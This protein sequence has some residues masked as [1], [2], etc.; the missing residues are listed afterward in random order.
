[1][2]SDKWSGLIR[3]LAIEFGGEVPA[4]LLMDFLVGRR[5][6]RRHIQPQPTQEQATTADT[7][8]PPSRAVPKALL[9]LKLTS[10]EDEMHEVIQW[11][12]ELSKRSKSELAKWD[13][14]DLEQLFKLPATD[15]T[16]LMEGILGPAPATP[17]SEV[18]KAK[19]WVT[20]QLPHL[21][22]ESWAII[23]EWEDWADNILTPPSHP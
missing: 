15:R 21:D 5:R 8:A 3:E 17:I 2:R 6:G 7:I 16:L 1:M 23:K 20:D 14:E 19:Q 11:F 4:L 12:Y 10:T 22:D 13:A 9:K 18:K